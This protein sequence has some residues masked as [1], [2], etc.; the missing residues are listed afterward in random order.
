VL[1]IADEV[2]C[3]FGRTGNMFGTTTFNLQPDMIVVAKALSS[4]YLPISG[5]MMTDKVY[6]ALVVESEK[7]GTFGH[8]YTYSAHPVPAAVALETLKIYEERDIIGHVRRV[9]GR[10]QDG[11]QRFADH[12]LVGEVRG[13]GLIGAIEFVADKK[14][15]QPFDPKLGVGAFCAKRAQEHGVILR[16]LGDAI[17]FCPPLIISEAE[18]DEMLARFGR[19]LDDTHAMM[20]ERGLAAA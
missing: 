6:Q 14:T 7:I 3:G 5:V 15:R 18:I 16:A 10:M 12:P 2:I 11:M 13:V 4:A 19:A 1:F 17:G 20:R 8:G 9:M